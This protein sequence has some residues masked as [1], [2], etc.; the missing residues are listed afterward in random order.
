M[1]RQSDIENKDLCRVLG[2]CSRYIDTELNNIRDRILLIRE[3]IELERASFYIFK[4]RKIKRIEILEKE[5]SYLL[6]REL[7]VCIEKKDLDYLLDKVRN[8]GDIANRLYMASC[9]NAKPQR[10]RTKKGKK[11]V[12]TKANKRTVQ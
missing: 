4:S 12:K 7:Q 8:T 3:K 1:R 6:K 11:N 9:I 10:L 5:F 2:N